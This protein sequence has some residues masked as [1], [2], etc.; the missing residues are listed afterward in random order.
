M[1]KEL[2]IILKNI[3]NHFP[4]LQALY[5]F[6]SFD[7]EYEFPD[8]DIDVAVLLP[9][10]R[11]KKTDSLTIA[12][13]GYKITKQIGKKVDIVNLR[14]ATAVFKK[15][16]TAKGTRLY[17]ADDY[18]ADEFEMLTLSY[19]QKLNEERK[20][21]LDDFLKTKRAYDI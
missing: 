2:N 6:G 5:L 1:K 9:A 18:A 17:C 14:E 7:T 19:Y 13:I 3:L 10:L 20:E 12:E 8:S 16:V 15:E 4:D 21:I 11:A